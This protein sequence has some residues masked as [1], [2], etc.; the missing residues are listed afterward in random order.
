MPCCC[1]CCCCCGGGACCWYGCCWY[2]CCWYC[3]CCGFIL[4]EANAGAG[5]GQ[6]GIL[7][8]PRAEKIARRS[9]GH[10]RLLVLPGVGL[11]LLLHVRVR[12]LHLLPHLR[13]GH[14]VALMG[15]VALHRSASFARVSGAN[16][17]R[18]RA[19][20]RAQPE[21]NETA[22][23]VRLDPFAVVPAF[24]GTFAASETLARRLRTF[25]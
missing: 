5:R 21:F 9:R 25:V 20:F 23:G 7:A 19:A 2:G 12:V 10:A 15:R 4:F 8:R 13:G 11:L 3:I 14:A 24:E 1:C 17:L 22:S 16:V 18:R 6:R